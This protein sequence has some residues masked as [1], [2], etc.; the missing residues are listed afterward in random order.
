MHKSGGNALP[1]EVCLH[2]TAAVS[3]ADCKYHQ[4]P[5]R[6]KK[7][8]STRR[9]SQFASYKVAEAFSSVLATRTSAA[10]AVP[11]MPSSPTQLTLFHAILPLSAFSASV[12]CSLDND[13]SPAKVVNGVLHEGGD[14]CFVLT[15]VGAMFRFRVFFS[16]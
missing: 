4:K 14:A 16:V 13:S 1:R 12:I 10:I 2:A 6:R 7:Q 8:L 3:Y 11:I 9:R 5:G 15:S